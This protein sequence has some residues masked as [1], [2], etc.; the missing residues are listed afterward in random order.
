VCRYLN[1]IVEAELFSCVTVHFALHGADTAAAQ[2]EALALSSSRTSNFAKT[3]KV[4]SLNLVDVPGDNQ[5]AVTMV[6]L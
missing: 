6:Q 2:L 5:M 4:Q 1:E 3:L